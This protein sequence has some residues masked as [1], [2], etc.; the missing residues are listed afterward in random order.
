MIFIKNDVYNEKRAKRLIVRGNEFSAMVEKLDDLPSYSVWDRLDLLSQINGFVNN[1]EEAIGYKVQQQSD[2]KS[3]CLCGI[4]GSAMCGDILIDYLAPISDKHVTVVRSVSLP[5]WVNI[6]TL[7]VVISYSGNTK[8]A[9]D[10]F[11]DS[12]SRG[13][14]MVCVSSGGELVKKAKE[15]NVPFIQVPPGI[16]PRAAL[17][18]LLGS[19]AVILQASGACAPTGALGEV[20]PFARSVQASLAPGVPTSN[21]AAKKIAQAL[22]RKVPIVYCPRSIR[23]V[24]V[25]W[26]NQIS[27]NAKVV[28]F[29]G[30]IPEMNHN[31]MVGWLSGNEAGELKPVFLVP[32]ALEPTVKKMTDVTIQMFNERGLDPV[33]VPMEGETIMENLIYGLILGDMVSYYIARIN[34]VDPMPVEVIGEFKKRIGK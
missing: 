1:I 17:G 7:V 33:V 20:I 15:N 2:V 13:L 22:Y 6:H 3:V 24:G 29:T 25:R 27:E 8:E 4:G 19:V 34:G 16:Q 28:A 11:Q 5:N 9:L 23:S 12:V 10:I 31:Q 18:Y 32:G 30:E 21:N 14:K 26:Q